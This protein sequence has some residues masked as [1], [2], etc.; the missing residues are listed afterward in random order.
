MFSGF[1]FC[2]VQGSP[3]YDNVRPLCYSDSDAVLLCFDISRPDI[4]DS[5]LKKVYSS[6]RVC[7]VWGFFCYSLSCFCLLSGKLRSW[8]S[9]PAHESS[10]LAARLICA[11]MSARWWS[12][13]IRSRPPSPMSRW[14]CG[15]ARL[16][17][18]HLC[19]FTV[20][21]VSLFLLCRVLL[22]RSSWVQRPTWNA[23]HSPLRKASTASS[24]PRQWPA[25]TSYKPCQ[26]TAPPA[27]SPKDSST[28][29]ASQICFPPPSRRRRPRAARSCE[30]RTRGWQSSYYPKPL[31]LFGLGEGGG[32]HGFIRTPCWTLPSPPPRNRTPLSRGG[33]LAVHLLLNLSAHICLFPLLFILLSDNKCQPE[34]ISISAFKRYASPLMLHLSEFIISWHIDYVQF[35][36]VQHDVM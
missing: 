26:R 4:V 30:W 27:A 15:A 11:R 20:L 36:N 16:T 1:F 28:S 21:T 35:G 25:W 22:W 17:C 23:Q 9:V 24:A 2:C 8:T 18:K 6:L 12:C 3:Y 14:A 33:H 13:P 5:S 19:V 29:R 7:T 32:G 34:K 10:L 31:A